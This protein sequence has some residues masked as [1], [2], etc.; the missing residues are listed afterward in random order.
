MPLALVAVSVKDADSGMCAAS[1]VAA[2]F[3][4]VTV[5]DLASRALTDAR[6]CA[7]RTVLV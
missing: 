4:I 3:G 5:N 7:I 2:V 1:A 6:V